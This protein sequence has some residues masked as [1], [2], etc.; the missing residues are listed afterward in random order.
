MRELLLTMRRRLNSFLI[1][2]KQAI[3]LRL[4]RGSI[5]ASCDGDYTEMIKTALDATDGV[6]GLG[7]CLDLGLFR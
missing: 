2:L 1:W 5:L 3:R 6:N 7:S 4:C